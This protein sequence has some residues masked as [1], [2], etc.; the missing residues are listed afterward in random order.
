VY[1]LT[2]WSGG[3]PDLAGHVK[4]VIAV[5]AGHV[6]PPFM[7]RVMFAWIMGL[8]LRESDHFAKLGEEYQIGESAAG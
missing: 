8:T 1:D 2:H 4:D 3:M 6:R 7:P 5:K